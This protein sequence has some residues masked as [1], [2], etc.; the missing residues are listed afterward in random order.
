MPDPLE[1]TR[2]GTSIGRLLL[3]VNGFVLLVPVLAIVLLRI[4]EGHLVRQT[5]ERLIAEATLIGE[6]WREAL[7][8]ASG[9]RL[10]GARI[11]PPDAPDALFFPYQP[12]LP[13]DPEPVVDLPTAPRIATER[14]GPEWI[15]GQRIKP[16]LDRQKLVNLSGARVVDRHGCVVATT[17]SQLGECIGDL[18]ELRAALAGRYHAV[19]RARYTDEPPPPLKS[20]SRRGEIRVFTAMP[21]FADGAIIGAV[22]M[23]RTSIDPLK[24]LWIHRSTLQWAL[25]GCLLL[26][27]A[28]SLFFARTIT[29]PVRAITDAAE[30]IARGE[31]RRPLPGGIVPAELHALSTALDQMTREL[32]ARADYVAEFAAQTSHELKTPL[33]A[34][35]GAAELLR[36]AD[37]MDE[38]QRARFVDNIDAA[39]ARM[40][41]LVTR[42]LHLARI[43]NRRGARPAETITLR[44]FLHALA[45]RHP[46]AP[47]RI[48]APEDLTLHIAPDDLE[49][50]IGNLL[51]N[52]LRHGDG[53]PI[54]L[55]AAAHGDRVAITVRDRGPGI[56]EGNQRRIF[57]RFF[58]TER[59]RGGTG[60][61]LAISRAIARGRGG[62]LDFQTSGDGTTFR[63]VL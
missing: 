11:Q 38:T 24:A 45:A 32:V 5:E 54:D 16:L 62:D 7:I 57:E 28:V 61:G 6:A 19:V 14:D 15:A 42:L 3:L 1:P 41:R 10:A 49:S 33:T 9:G 43:E 22:R 21:L 35:R 4:Y 52:A 60:L 18:P 48:D 30:A 2:R 36:D 46:D 23:S 27:I 39:A 47:I 34:I 56:S 20:I 51:D 26:T 37:G 63:L 44:P 31:P 55:T 12:V 25:G 13:L 58:T 17:G 53:A 40:Q 8:D 59:D 29:R 50:A